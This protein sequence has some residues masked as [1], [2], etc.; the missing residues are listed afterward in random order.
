MRLPFTKDISVNPLRF[1]KANETEKDSVD[2]F[3]KSLAPIWFIG[4][5]V[6]DNAAIGPPKR[7]L[8]RPV[9][10]ERVQRLVIPVE[11]R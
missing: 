11:R 10:V 3:T 7:E 2:V 5:G 6:L 4:R 9:F 8:F 1:Q